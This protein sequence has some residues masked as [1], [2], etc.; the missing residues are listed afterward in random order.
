MMKVII[1]G[2]GGRMGQNLLKA[3]Y[4]D[5][6]S[7]IAG[8][9]EVSGHQLIGE[10][11]SLVLG[12]ANLGVPVVDDLSEVIDQA[13]VVIDFT[14]PESTMASL[15]I[16]K[17]AGK[18]MVI[19][20]TGLQPAQIEEI[21]AIAQ[22][23]PCLLAP[24]MGIGVNLMFQVA[25]EIAA[26]LGDDYEIEITEAHHSQKKDAPSGTALKLAEMITNSLKRNLSEVGVYGR[27]GITGVRSRKE[28]GI[29]AIRAGDII[30]EHTVYYVGNSERLE[31]THR[32]H[33]R[34]VFAKGAIRA[35]KFLAQAAP[36]K[37]YDMLDVLGL[38]GA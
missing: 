10:D 4:G 28:I 2:V 12:T 15:R 21:Q 9:T 30:G 8:A 5:L 38:K 24:N 36:G 18:A 17:A 7:Y 33:D 6:H 29:H 34:M 32:A 1:D 13:D 37:L 26:I 25:A 31:L 27:K 19:G 16:A 22:E 3:A 35:A 23:V 20:T 14:S 11:V